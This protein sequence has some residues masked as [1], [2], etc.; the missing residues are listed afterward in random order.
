MVSKKKSRGKAMVTMDLYHLPKEPVDLQCPLCGHQGLTVVKKSWGDRGKVLIFW[1]AAAI[2][3]AL[4]FV[5]ILAYI[6]LHMI[7]CNKDR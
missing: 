3:I 1:T 4:F 2:F 6:I 5:F 7:I